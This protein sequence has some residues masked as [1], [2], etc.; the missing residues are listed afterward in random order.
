MHQQTY[1]KCKKLHNYFL[2]I[3]SVAKQQQQRHVYDHVRAR[4]RTYDHPVK[5]AVSRNNT[6]LA[7]NP[8]Y[9]E[10][11]YFTNRNMANDEPVYDIVK[12]QPRQTNTDNIKVVGNLAYVE[13][14]TLAVNSIY[15]GGTLHTNDSEEEDYENMYPQPRQ[16]DGNNIK[17]VKN[18]AYPGTKKFDVRSAHDK[19]AYFANSNTAYEDSEYY[20]VMNPQS[21]QSIT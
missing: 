20:N 15:E 14:N 21:K 1:S 11:G 2:Y 7:V 3:F 12:P 17:L 9:D 5:K 8:I 10:A 18:P 4:C 13:T 19:G 6:M 16:T